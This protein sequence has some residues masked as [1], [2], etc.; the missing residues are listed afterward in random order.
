M[1]T[2]ESAF[3]PCGSWRNHATSQW[4]NSHNFAVSWRILDHLSTNEHQ[5]FPF[6]RMWLSIWS[7]NLSEGKTPKDPLLFHVALI[8]IRGK[9]SI[10]R[11]FLDGF[12][13]FLVQINTQGSPFVPSSSWWN[14]KTSQWKNSHN[15]AIS[16]PILDLFG[17]NDYLRIPFCP[18][19][20][21]ME[22]RNLSGG[23]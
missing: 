13:I 7:C 4:Y 9:I 6:C 14:H 17:A 10:T 23:K 2:Q 11:T 22:S 8:G 16:W 15:S 3:V 21:S 1:N 12:L 5:R 19:F 20:F 18:I